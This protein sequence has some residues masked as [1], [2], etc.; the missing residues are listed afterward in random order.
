MHHS[1]KTVKKYD[2][3]DKNDKKASDI[4]NFCDTITSAD[5]YEETET[6]RIIPN[7]VAY[8]YFEGVPTTGEH[9]MII[10]KRHLVKFVDFNDQERRE[11]FALLSKYEGDGFNVYA[12]SAQNIHRSQAHQH[13]HLIRLSTEEP[14]LIFALKK[15]YFMFHI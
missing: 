15:P 4:C 11:M 13:T 8:D 5:I 10:P 14:K 9:F 12:R 6:M 7:R 2:Q 3:Y 1:R